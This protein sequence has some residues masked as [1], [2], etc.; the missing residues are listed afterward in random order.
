MQRVMLL[1]PKGGSGKTTTG[2]APIQGVE[3]YRNQTGVTRAWQMRVPA[4][5]DRVVVDTPAGFRPPQLADLIRQ[6]D[7]VLVPVLPSHIDIDAVAGF[8]EELRRLQPVRSGSTRV[9]V[10]ANRVRP[11]SSLFRELDAF[12]QRGGF[13]FVGRLR[14]SQRYL[15]AAAR[16][17]GVHEVPGRGFETDAK[18]WAPLLAWIAGDGEVSVTPLAPK[19]F[20]KR[21]ER[22]Q[23]ALFSVS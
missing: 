19:R 10:V 3:A 20:E 15:R 2:Y 23:T 21:S 16:G 5:T 18:Q 14:E 9:A 12:L 1:N 22:L 8:L 7:C 6:A 17:I 11:R 4:G 13:P